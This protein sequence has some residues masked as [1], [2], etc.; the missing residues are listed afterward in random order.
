VACASVSMMRVE[1][2]LLVYSHRPPLP[3]TCRQKHTSY[4][5]PEERTKMHA[6]GLGPSLTTEL[7]AQLNWLGY[8]LWSDL[9]SSVL[10]SEADATRPVYDV[11]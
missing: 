2:E 8:N 4:D 6:L 9:P 5:G 7:N 3:L 11:H 1:R 10:D